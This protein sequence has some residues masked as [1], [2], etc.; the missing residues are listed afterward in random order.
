MSHLSPRAAEL[1]QGV[2]QQASV[3]ERRE[4]V[5]QR[6]EGEWVW[7]SFVARSMRVPELNLSL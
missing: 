5:L 1:E 4:N 3:N 2:A 7:A 6:W